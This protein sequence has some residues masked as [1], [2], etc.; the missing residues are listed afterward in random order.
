MEEIIEHGDTIDRSLTDEIELDP[1]NNWLR[2]GNAV[3]DY[4]PRFGIAY[5]IVTALVAYYISKVEYLED[6]PAW[7]YSLVDTESLAGRFAD[8]VLGYVTIIIYYTLFEYFSKGKSL[9]KYITQTRAVGLDGQKIN[10]RQSLLRSLC[11]C[12]PFEPLSFF[13]EGP[14][15]WHDRLTD[16]VV[17]NERTSKL[18]G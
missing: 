8:I 13:G 7:V 15:G 6:I 4:I 3:I 10:F 1:A 14:G 17:I 5:L 12:I 11:R 16:T 18:P 2:L 9:G